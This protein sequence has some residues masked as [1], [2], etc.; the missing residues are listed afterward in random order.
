[1]LHESL[2]EEKRA[3]LRLTKLAKREV[4]PDALAA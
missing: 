1:M 2:E 3:D 4:N